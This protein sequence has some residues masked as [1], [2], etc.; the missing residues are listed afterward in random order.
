MA[1]YLD[2]PGV[3]R[4]WQKIKAY[5]VSHG[6]VSA[7][8]IY[9]VGSIYM[10]VI[11]KN[12]SSLF[13]G[14]WAVWGTGKVP[15][16]VDSSQTEFNS[17]EKSGGEKSHTL[18]VA[19][20]PNHTHAQVAHTHTVGLAS[21][22]HTHTIPALSGTAASAGAHSHTGNYVKECAS[23]TARQR[24]TNT[25]SGASQ[26]TVANSNGAHTHSVTTNASTTGTIS[27]SHTHTVNGGAS[28]TGAT[29]SGTTH[30][31][32]QPYI[33]CYMWKRTA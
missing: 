8:D 30:N 3:E 1:E 25:Q 32:L 19:E 17:V 5:V 15:V 4:L 11:N 7:L 22:N 14:T 28:T 9:P 20:M 16:G 12:P 6:G 33:T 2:K 29:G 18:S 26:Y 10:S 24:V 31:N 27:A 13:G 21:A 23:G